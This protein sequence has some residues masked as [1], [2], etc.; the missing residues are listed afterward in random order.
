[1]KQDAPALL[2]VFGS[3][4]LN[5]HAQML[6]HANTVQESSTRKGEALGKANASFVLI[7]KLNKAKNAIIERQG[8]ERTGGRWSWGEGLLLLLIHHWLGRR[9][10]DDQWLFAEPAGAVE[11]TDRN[12]LDVSSLSSFLNPEKHFSLL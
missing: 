1:M 12:T 11:N 6:R 5:K 2:K 9:A 3:N 10:A 8:Q 4:W 7:L